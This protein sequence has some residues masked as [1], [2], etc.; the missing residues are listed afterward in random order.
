MSIA[1]NYVANT[2]AQFILIPNEEQFCIGVGGLFSLQITDQNGCR[3]L[4]G[5]AQDYSSI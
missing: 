5:G 4:K 2:K 1:V 3:G